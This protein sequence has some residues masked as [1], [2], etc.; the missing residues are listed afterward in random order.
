MNILFYTILFIIG[1]VVGGLWAVQSR[2]IP[3]I[4]DL[5]KT[6]YRN[7]P[8]EDLISELTY[9]LIGG[10]S[11]V[12]LANILNISMNQFDILNFIIYI[13]AMMY[14]SALVLIGGI[15]RVYSKIEKKTLAFGIISSILYM[16]Y[17]CI[18]DL[19][20]IH[21]NVIY[22]GIYIILLVIDSFLLRRF[23]KDS[24]I[25]NLLMVLVMILVF[26]DLKTLTYT[27]VMALIAIGF[28]T[29]LLKYQKKKN[30][31]K[32]IK[33]N[34][35]PVGFFVAASNVIVLFMVRIFENYLI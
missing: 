9:I 33:I 27:L 1:S 17:L 28:Y 13:F 25:V 19:A 22:L 16:L 4:L 6:H 30:G 26:T 21:L 15:D 20:S 8:K 2:E 29:L 7:R 35:I 32:K 10:V 24:Y 12:V 14:I 11:A 34:E 23:A 5:K 18:V 3:K 31:N